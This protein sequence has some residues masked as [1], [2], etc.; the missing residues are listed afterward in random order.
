MV[1]PNHLLI[2]EKITNWTNLSDNIRFAVQVGVAYGSNTE[3]VK[4]LL[5]LSIKDHPKILKYPSAFVRFSSFG[6]SS[7]DFS[8]YFFSKEYL[9]IEDVKSDIRL[10]IDKLFRE[11]NITIPFPQRDLHIIKKD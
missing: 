1:V 10:N 6:E 9:T 11:N 2:N 4:K 3:L 7:L 5:L 8:L